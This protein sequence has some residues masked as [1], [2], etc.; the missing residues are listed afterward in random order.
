MMFGLRWE[1]LLMSDDVSPVI[2]VF[3]LTTRNYKVFFFFSFFLTSLSDDQTVAD[4]QFCLAAPLSSDIGACRKE[5]WDE[6]WRA[7]MQ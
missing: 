3:C 7:C 5:K 6:S 2:E 1:R 4:R